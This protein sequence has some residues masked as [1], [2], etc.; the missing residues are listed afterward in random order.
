MKYQFTS[1]LSLVGRIGTDYSQQTVERKRAYYGI[2]NKEGLYEIQKIY[3]QETNADF[4][5]SARKEIISGLTLSGNFGGN[6]MNRKYDNQGSS[7]AKLVV[8][9]VYALS[10]AKEPPTATLY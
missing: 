5:L 1:W 8:P 7:V 2:N 3:R 4:L 9:N 6:I 10:N